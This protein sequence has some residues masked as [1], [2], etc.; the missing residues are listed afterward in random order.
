MKKSQA[1]MVITISALFV[2][3]LLVDFS[4][5]IM[6]GRGMAYDDNPDHSTACYDDPNDRFKMPRSLPVWIL[7]MGISGWC[8]FV[9]YP[10]LYLHGYFQT[11]YAKPAL[12]LAR[13]LN[14]VELIWIVLWSVIC[15][16]LVMDSYDN[17]YNT[18]SHDEYVVW[19]AGCIM[20]A[21]QFLAI[22]RTQL[23]L[24]TVPKWF[25]NTDSHDENKKPEIV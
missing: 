4:V 19:V 21:A 24:H 12:A 18:S 20:L 10:M 1:N 6:A 23:L 13:I 7:A 8:M 3:G 15:L 9:I 17:C 2:I 16:I 22:I 11:N 14:I 25:I 5:M